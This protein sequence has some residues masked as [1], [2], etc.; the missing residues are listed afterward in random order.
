[1]KTVNINLISFLKNKNQGAGIKNN[2][3]TT[4]GLVLGIVFIFAIITGTIMYFSE[5]NSYWSIYI[6]AGVCLIGWCLNQA[7]HEKSSAIIL[8]G[9]I[10]AIVQFNIYRGLGIHDVA[11]IAWPAVIFFTGL[12]FGSRAIRYFTALIALLAILARFSPNAQ[13]FNSNGDTS[14]LVVLLMILA[15]FSLIAQSIIRRNETALQQVLQSEERAQAIFNSV[16]DAIFIHDALT[17]AILDV[18]DKMLEMYGYSRQEAVRLDIEAISSNNPSYRQENAME[19]MRKAAGTGPQLFE[20]QAKDKN[21]QV[22][23]VDVNMKLAVIGGQ[24]QAVISVRNISERK[25]AEEA[26][27]SLNTELEQRVASRTMA[28]EDSNKE[29]EAFAYSVSHDLRAPLRAMNGFSNALLEDY[30]TS[31]DEQGQ[32]Y[33]VRMQEAAQRMGQLINDLLDLSLITRTEIIHQNV[34]LSSLAGEIAT[35]LKMQAPQRYVEFEITNNMVVSG[36]ANLLKIV[37]ENLLNNA[38][39]FT[40]QC[41]QTLIQVGKTEQAGKNVYFVRD[42]GAGF[43]MVYANK[44]FAP[45]Q[46]LHSMQ[47]FPGTGIGLATVQRIIARHGGRIWA[48]AA[49]NQGATFYFTL[50]EL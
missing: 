6:L 4:V 13:N 5:M 8:I 38:Y 33:L 17:G 7:G 35:E 23:W 31:L 42:N 39:K 16:N 9:A 30:R 10:L 2:Q 47:A 26:I 46:R 21:G 40:S 49:V 37:L 29:L 44:L 1:M 14:D 48:N 24:P 32:Q 45:F 18:N 15:S 27:R 41:S 34:N 20:W 19:W 22:F 43:D 36:D 25:Q 3:Q 28:L 11:I 50:D 12:L